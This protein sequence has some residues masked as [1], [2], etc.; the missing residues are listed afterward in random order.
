MPR[1]GSV[2]KSLQQLLISLYRTIPH[3]LVWSA[4]VPMPQLTI[5]VHEYSD[6]F[7]DLNIAIPTLFQGQ[8]NHI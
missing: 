6:L 1:F 2:T 4:P 7:T 8:D 3:S 5:A